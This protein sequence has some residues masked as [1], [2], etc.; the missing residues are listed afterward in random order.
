LNNDELKKQGGILTGLGK[1][2]KIS[3]ELITFKGRL[4]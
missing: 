3:I 1:R 2:D 4:L